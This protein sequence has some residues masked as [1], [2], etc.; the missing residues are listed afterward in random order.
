[1][2]C[3]GA[4]HASGD[5]RRASSVAP[6]SVGAPTLGRTRSERSVE[7]E[8][9]T[10]KADPDL[11]E[12][13]ADAEPILTV[14]FALELPWSLRIADIAFL[15]SDSSEGWP[16]WGPDAMGDLAGMPPLPHGRQP[17]YRA[18]LSQATVSGAR[19]LAAVESSFPD[20]QG[21]PA[22][23]EDPNEEPR[24]LRSAVLLSIY[25]KVSETPLIEEEPQ[26]DIIEWLSRRLDEAL[27]FLNRYIVIL[28]ALNDEWHISSVSRIDLQRRIPWELSM[29]PAPQ[30]WHD[31][32]GTVDAHV[33]WRDDL[34]EERPQEEV[35][36][37]VE[38][39]HR[40]RAGEIPFFDW[41]ELYQAAEHHLGSGRNA[42]AVI[43]S[44]TAIE[45]LIN[46]LFR[47]TWALLEKD[48]AK[49]PGVLECG[50]KNQLNAH[51]PRLLE[52]R[53]DLRDPELPP[54]R[55]HRDC[56]LLRNNI[57]HKGRKPSAPEAMN[58]KLAT[59]AFAGWIGANLKPDPRTDWIK[60]FLQAPKR[61]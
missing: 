14:T 37:A 16:G 55:W 26:E 6:A 36:A 46:S 4:E 21:F 45:V 17:R 32:S 38:L 30:G 40:Y 50:F 15:V 9:V 42:Q 10:R 11:I 52:D 54:G 47:V 23:N 48:E 53:L 13:E 22:R 31:P 1:M 28:G 5:H 56:Y 19:P 35:M 29:N 3:R 25:C 59:R 51:L 8:R 60:T 39:I 7:I 43:F 49:L 61:S 57:V 27:E 44:T 58:A 33:H 2:F 24:E 34:P 41:I 20:W 12:P 18:E